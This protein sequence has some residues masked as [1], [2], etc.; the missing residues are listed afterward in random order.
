MASSAVIDLSA[1]RFA[2]EDRYWFD[3]GYE[4]SGGTPCPGCTADGKVP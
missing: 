2:R 3:P 4:D 1:V